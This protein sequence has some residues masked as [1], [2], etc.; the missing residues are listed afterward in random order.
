MRRLIA[1]DI[2]SCVRAIRSWVI[3][4]VPGWLIL[5]GGLDKW[6]LKLPV[7]ELPLKKIDLSRGQRLDIQLGRRLLLYKDLLVPRAAGANLSRVVDLHVRQT[8]PGGGTNLT[9]QHV[10]EGK[11]GLNLKVGIYL[12]KKQVLT[13]LSEQT[14]R[15]DL[16]IRTV[17]IAEEPLA[18][19]LWDNKKTTDRPR[20]VWALVLLMLVVGVAGFW[21][22]Q[23]LRE[24]KALSERISDLEQQKT[25]LG[26]EAIAIR[27]Q[28]DAEKTDYSSIARDLYLFQVEYQ[29]I[30]ILLDLTTMLSDET[31]ISEFAIDGENLRFSGFTQGDV[32]EVIRLIRP[33]PWAERVDLDGPV[34]FDSFSRKNRF[35]LLV[36]LRRMNGAKP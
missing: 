36:S 12:L 35:D 30:P 33:L 6:S 19:P 11:E 20:K 1:G 26:A 23:E 7:E 29:R 14:G 28:M 27:A 2:K 16:V 32:T 31:W 34:S 25:D 5:P 22:W 4:S 17:C 21:S 3:D 13:D 24:S 8:M 10:V 15:H 18:Q 9:W